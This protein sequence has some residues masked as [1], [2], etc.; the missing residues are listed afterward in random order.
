MLRAVFV[1]CFAFAAAP[2]GAQTAP[3]PATPDPELVR[4]QQALA[5]LA[6]DDRRDAAREYYEGWRGL[7]DGFKVV[8]TVG[9]TDRTSG[10]GDPGQ[11]YPIDLDG[12]ERLYGVEVGFFS[13]RI[14][15][16]LC[17]KYSAGCLERYTE[18][19]QDP[20]N[21]ALLDALRLDLRGG[22]G[23]R[24]EGGGDEPGSLYFV[25]L[26]WEVPLTGPDRNPLD[27]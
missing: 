10:F 4:I 12:G 2:A 27:E 24:L 19:G 14:A 5:R 16:D 11:H 17:V 15:R 1:L 6:A 9:L 23:T 18:R 26:K 25:G 21:W 3:A 20:M 7:A 22:Y 13:K 8:S